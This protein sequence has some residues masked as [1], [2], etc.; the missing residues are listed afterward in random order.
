MGFV[1]FPARG[2]VVPLPLWLY[3]LLGL[4][5]IGI[6]SAFIFSGWVYVLGIKLHS[7]WL[8]AV[9]LIWLILALIV[10]SILLHLGIFKFGSEIIG[11]KVNLNL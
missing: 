6:P 5:L 7:K 3:L 8:K 9:S 10:T 4:V 11:F 2:F 1:V